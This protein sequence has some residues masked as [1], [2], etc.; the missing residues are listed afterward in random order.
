VQSFV[1]LEGLNIRWGVVKINVEVPLKQVM[2]ARGEGSRGAAPLILKLGTRWGVG[3]DQ[4]H[5]SAVL[6]PEKRY[7]TLRIGGWVGPRAGLDG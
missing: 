6:N 1:P 7:G 2:Q 5:A 3:F 4:R